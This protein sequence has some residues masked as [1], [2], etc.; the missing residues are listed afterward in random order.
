MARITLLPGCMACVGFGMTMGAVAYGRPPAAVPADTIVPVASLQPVSA[1]APVAPQIGSYSDSGCRLDLGGERGWPCGEDEF[2][3]TVVGRTLHTLHANATYNCCP[4]EIV[5]SLTVAG[6]TLTL[7]EEEILTVPCDCMCCYDVEATVVGLTP[8][9]YR[10]E[11]FW[12]DYETGTWQCHVETVVIPGAM[13]PRGGGW[14]P[15]APDAAAPSQAL[16]APAQPVGPRLERYGDSGCLYEGDGDLY[17]PCGEDEFVFTVV[18]RTL[19][20]LHA[21]ATYNCC[22]DEIVVRLEVQGERLLFTEEEILP[23]CFCL[24]C[25][26]VEATVVDLAPGEYTVEYF[27]FDY[28]TGQWQCHVAQIVVPPA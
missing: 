15:A 9:Q 2:A 13:L 12:F 7:T 23:Q 18:G 10:V 28:E 5:V 8:G 26:D 27:W 21:N 20:T 22:P 1:P 24:C 16:P 25:Y 17:W 6:H 14:A 4:D 11:Y 3:F 19:H